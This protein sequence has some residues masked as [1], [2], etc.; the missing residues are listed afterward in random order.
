[1]KPATRPRPAALEARLLRVDP[2]SWAIRD[3]A[4]GRLAAQFRAGDL[5]VLNDAAT[6]PA[7]LAARAE[8]GHKLE[9][10]L[11]GPSA[12]NNA[13]TAVLFGEGTWRTRTEHRPAP[14]PLARGA[15][16]AFGDDLAARVSAVSALSPR[17]VQLTFDRDEEALWSALYRHGR[18]VQYSHLADP[19]DLWDVQTAFAGRPWSVETPSAARPLNAVALA[20][21]RVH[22]VA[23]AS[24]THAAGLSATGDHA[25]DRA[26]PLPERSEVP[27]ATV[28]AVAAAR[29][30][31]GRVIAAGTSTVRALEANALA[32]GGVLR[33]ACGMA[34]LRIGTGFVPRIVG[35][36]LTGMHEAGTSHFEMLTAFA[37]RTLLGLA[38]SHAE[39]HGYLG[40]EFG[41]AMLLLNY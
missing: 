5:L 37:P 14:R 6:L 7:S 23:I 13:W 38:L 18:P 20:A 32:H 28:E 3:V 11:A 17:L 25:I 34:G 12:G 9:V 16:L 19:L 39:D 8:D 24:V 15:A 22:G 4:L 21:L 41:D 30:R 10:R 26:L 36:L 40:E 35:G 33:A 2:V 27:L 29:A 1:M 31:G